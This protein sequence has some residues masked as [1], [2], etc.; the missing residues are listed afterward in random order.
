MPLSEREQVL[1]FIAEQLI[2]DHTQGVGHYELA[3][4]ILTIYSGS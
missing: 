2:V 3:G 1:G 4:S